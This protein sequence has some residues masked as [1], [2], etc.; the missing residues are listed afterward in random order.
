MNLA[1][2]LGIVLLVSEIALGVRRRAGRTGA[3]AADRGSLI[4]LWVVIVT[5]ITVAY[6]VAMQTPGAD[7]G[8]WASVGRFAG[9][10]CFIAG[11][12]LR[13]YSIVYLGR[14]FTVNV[15]IAADHQV[16]DQ[17]P[18][19]NIRHPSYTGAMLAFL[20]LG[21]CLANGWAV[22]ATTVPIWSVFLWRIAVEERAL[23]QGLGDAYR[24]YMR[25]T[26]RLIP[27]VY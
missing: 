16:I 6:S 3:Q 25:R 26:Q 22:L 27:G 18:Y 20:G 23:L 1:S 5:S 24:Q 15:A 17:G 8:S 9:L 14:F 2:A 11:L 10:A 12:T 7:F 21:L 13:W 4:A 19:R